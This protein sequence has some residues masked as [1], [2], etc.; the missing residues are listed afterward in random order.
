MN[1]KWYCFDREGR[2]YH[3]QWIQKVDNQH[4]WYYVGGDGAMV[5]NTNVGGYSINANGECYY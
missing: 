1:G 3:D 2:M 5:T 4:I